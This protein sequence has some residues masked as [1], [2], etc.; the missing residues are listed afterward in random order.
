MT[1]YIKLSFLIFI[2]IFA[3]TNQQQK[4]KNEKDSSQKQ[5]HSSQDGNS[6]IKNSYYYFPAPGEILQIINKEKLIFIK[7]LLI[8]IEDWKKQEDI[9][10]QVL[11]LGGYVANLAYISLFE[12]YDLSH[13]YIAE[14]QKTSKICNIEVREISKNN[15]HKLIANGSLEDSL[16]TISNNAFYEIIN[17]LEKNKR[18][19]GV[20]IFS[21][22]AFIESLYI[23]THVVEKYSSKNEVVK[24]ISEQKN[25]LVNLLSYA[26]ENKENSQTDYY[27]IN[28]IKQ[29]K[30]IFDSFENEQ[31]EQNQ[32]NFNLSEKNY[33]ELKEKI[34]EIREKQYQ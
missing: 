17:Y 10:S 18:Q 19:D 8:P 15:I 21:T 32:N 30:G 31:K 25:A 5:L 14:L 24:K 4:P 1:K 2:L 27:A 13:E 23:G 26:E 20:A 6:S 7:D 9:K 16:L 33:Y 22:G 11:L 12:E 29:L 28:E 3:C 34:K